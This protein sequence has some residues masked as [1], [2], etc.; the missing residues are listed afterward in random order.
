MAQNTKIQFDV[1]IFVF[2]VSTEFGAL[3]KK[4]LHIQCDHHKAQHFFFAQKA[5]KLKIISMRKKIP[6]VS[7][8][9]IVLN[10][11]KS[12]LG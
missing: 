5:K 3:T 12:S 6:F 8:I 9:E 4:S 2:C 10:Q 1:N 11:Q 7:K